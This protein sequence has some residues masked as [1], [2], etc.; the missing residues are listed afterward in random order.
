VRFELPASKEFSRC[1]V[2]WTRDGYAPT[3]GAM[4]MRTLD[5]SSGAGRMEDLPPGH[6][7]F[8]VAPAEGGEGN[9]PGWWVGTSVETDVRSAE[10]S[11]V[12]VRLEAG[13]RWELSVIR[14]DTK[15][16]VERCRVA[17]YLPSGE[18]TYPTLSYRG[19]RRDAD[20]VTSDTRGGNPNLGLDP[21]PAG[22]YR[23][24]LSHPS[25]RSAWRT[26]RIEPRRTTKIKVELLPR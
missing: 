19:I 17:L 24:R 6:Y 12:E 22:T 18:V 13:G 23:L 1:N 8:R 14:A 5:L 2:T 7:A 21:L 20:S 15:E 3:S 25:F 11:V 4:Y 10:E 26:L 9:R 16:F